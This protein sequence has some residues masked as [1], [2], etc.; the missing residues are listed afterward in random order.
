MEPVFYRCKRCEL[1]TATHPGQTDLVC[2]GCKCRPEKCHNC[3]G[4][5]KFSQL[6][7]RR[8]RVGLCLE[9]YSM[10]LDGKKVTTSC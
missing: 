7:T 10:Y 1:I 5:T 3:G 2:D 9:C 4:K 6:D 8:G